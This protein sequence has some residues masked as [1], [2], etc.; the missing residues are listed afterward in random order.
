MIVLAETLGVGMP[1]YCSQSSGEDLLDAATQAAYD[2]YDFVSCFLGQVDNF[3][4]LVTDE[5][6]EEQVMV[7]YWEGLYLYAEPA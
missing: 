5:D 1:M 3:I 2:I 6:G 4:F 7:G